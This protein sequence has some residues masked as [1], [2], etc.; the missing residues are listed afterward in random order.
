M[1]RTAQAKPKS[2]TRTTKI[3]AT[4]KKSTRTPAKPKFRTIEGAEE[5]KIPINLPI[6][7]KGRNLSKASKI[8]ISKFV[9]QIYALDRHPIESILNSFCLTH[10]TFLNWV[11]QISEI[12]T[13]YKESQ[14]EKSLAYFA[15]LRPLAQTSLERRVR[16]EVRT[17]TT[18]KYRTPIGKEQKEIEGVVMMVETIEKEIY[19][20][21]SDTAIQVA[22]YNQDGG[23]FQRNPVPEAP[24][25]K[26][27]N[28]P[29]INWID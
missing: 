19:I 20:P 4:T 22:L 9:C 15:R 5:V 6:P 8:K 27:V 3:K 16:G 29:P 14:K 1:G 12:S 24:E 10:R 26:D 28:I 13:L 2:T 21:P 17:L 25:E 18:K 11:Y 7:H 23:N